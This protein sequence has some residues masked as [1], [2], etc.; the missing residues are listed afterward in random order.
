MFIEEGKVNVICF[1]YT[2][3]IFNFIERLY[4]KKLIVGNLLDNAYFDIVSLPPLLK[5]SYEIITF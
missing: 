4:L 5:Q 2:S 1:K 3:H